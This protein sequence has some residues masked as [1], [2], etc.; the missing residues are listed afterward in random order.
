MLNAIQLYD[1]DVCMS[2]K[3]SALLFSKSEGPSGDKLITHCL[4]LSITIL[5]MST[6]ATEPGALPRTFRPEPI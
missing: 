6:T 2:G 1:C 3:I 5:A 4:F